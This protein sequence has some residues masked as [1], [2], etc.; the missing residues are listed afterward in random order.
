M[1]LRRTLAAPALVASLA[2]GCN[3]PSTLAQPDVSPRAVPSGTV[4]PVAPLVGPS[5]APEL[6]ASTAPEVVA[7]ERPAYPWL[8]DAHASVPQPVDALEERFAPPDDFARV[9]VAPRSFAAFL[10][11]LPLAAA[12][13]PVVSHKGGV[14]LPPDHPNL[15]AVVAID[16]GAGDLQQCADSVIRLHAEWRFGLGERAIGYRAAAGL[17]M[18]LKRFAD[19]ERLSYDGHSL[20]SSRTAR[21]LPLTH[22]MLRLWLDEVFGWANTV[23]LA[24]EARPVDADELRPGDFFVAPGAP[25][26]A[27]LILDLARAPNGR[28]AVLLGQGYMP[29]QSLHVL[30]PAPGSA[31]F[32]IDEARREMV[33]PFWR[34]FPFASLRRLDG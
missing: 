20:T 25:G 5:S 23:S 17:E 33:T 21:S 32:P 3:R 6:A 13:T 8:Q 11:R 1:V 19:G 26:H 14:V 12:G 29:A 16:V 10:R 4:S 34:P 24:K 22:P 30:R 31:W 9:P 7:T 28:R 2:T 27:V 15:A 18:S